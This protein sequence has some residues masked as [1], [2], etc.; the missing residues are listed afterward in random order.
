MIG[1]IGA[2]KLGTSFGVY[3]ARHGYKVAF[4]NRTGQ[5]AKAAAELAGGIMVETVEDLLHT[6]DWIGI[7]TGDDQVGEVVLNLLEARADLEGKLFFH[8][9]GALSSDRLKELAKEGAETASLHPLQSFSDPQTGVELLSSAYFSLEGTE[10]AKKWLGEMLANL[11]NPFFVIT[12][13]QKSLY[14]AAASIVSN[15]LVSVVDYGFLL[16]ETAGI[17]EETARRALMPLIEGSVRNVR[18]RGTVEGLTGPIVR[19]DFGTI[20][21]HINAIH[22][23]APELLDEYKQLARMTLKTAA[24]GQLKDDYKVQTLTRLLKD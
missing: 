21:G 23:K 14:H 6:C 13:A 15:A 24:R 9:S 1:I 12:A 7:A 18:D 16:M 2:G 11:K 5:K 22:A 8:M 19:G 10:Q 20:E 4:F 17:D 3:L